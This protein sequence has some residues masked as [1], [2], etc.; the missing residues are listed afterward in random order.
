MKEYSPIQFLAHLVEQIYD[1][2]WYKMDVKEFNGIIHR[3]EDSIWNHYFHI[4]FGFEEFVF[5]CTSKFPNNCQ[6]DT[7]NLILTIN[8]DEELEKELNNYI[9]IYETLDIKR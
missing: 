6:F 2:G 3:I 9:K 7:E 1:N 5:E 8:K 4:G